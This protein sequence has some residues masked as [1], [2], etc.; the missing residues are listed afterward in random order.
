MVDACAMA[1]LG[2]ALNLPAHKVRECLDP[3]ANVQ[4]RDSAGGPALSSLRP[5][6]QRANARLQVERLANQARR[7]RLSLAQDKLQAA[8]RAQAGL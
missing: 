3:T 6:L 8:T 7:D 2:H 1:Q 4:S 5:S